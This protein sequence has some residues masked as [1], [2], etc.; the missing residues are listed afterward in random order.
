MLLEFA[1]GLPGREGH[2]ILRLHS[3]ELE[4]ALSP[5]LVHKGVSS[6]PATNVELRGTDI[7][8]LEE[9]LSV[10]HVHGGGIPFAEPAAGPNRWR[11]S[12][13]VIVVVAAWTTAR[14]NSNS[15]LIRLLSVVTFEDNSIFFFALLP[16]EIV[17]L[18][19]RDARALKIIPVHLQVFY[20]VVQVQAGLR[21]TLRRF[22]DELDRRLLQ[23]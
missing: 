22:R 14:W 2:V 23:N 4:A 18:E 15:T 16:I 19:V 5:F 13:A 1:F 17:L 6:L 7:V 12:E 21:I 20:Q 8:L 9:L 3:C 11:V 10:S